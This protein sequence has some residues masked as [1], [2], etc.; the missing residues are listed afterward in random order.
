MEKVIF[1]KIEEYEPIKEFLIVNPC[2]DK[3]KEFN[4]ILAPQ[5]N[6]Y[7]ATINRL[8][9]YAKELPQAHKDAMINRKMDEIF[10][11]GIDVKLLN[12]DEYIERLKTKVRK[13]HRLFL[14]DPLR[15]TTEEEIEKNKDLL[16][17]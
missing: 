14:F 17:S 5:G 12:K 8:L 6:P 9:N 4:H 11:K 16:W 2:T 15:A 1:L 13:G 10:T 3:V 7:N